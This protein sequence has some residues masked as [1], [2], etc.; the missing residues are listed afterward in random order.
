MKKAI[1]YLSIYE[2]DE[3]FVFATFQHFNYYVN[4]DCSSGVIT[5]A[6]IIEKNDDQLLKTEICLS[7]FDFRYEKFYLAISQLLNPKETELYLLKINDELIDRIKAI[8]SNDIN[9]S[10]I[11]PQGHV[12]L[13]SD[14]VSYDSSRLL[15]EYVVDRFENIVIEIYTSEKCG[16]EEPHVHVSINNVLCC[17]ISLVD[18]YQVL[19]YYSSIRSKTLKKAKMMITNKLSYMRLKWN[20]FS[21]LVK[22]KLDKNGTPT[23]ETYKIKQN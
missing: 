6:T 14:T 11:D 17:K 19:K 23:S 9:V 16:Y 15:T 12:L 10:L 3:S 20:E 13:A 2:A 4:F 8:M 5:K 1:G 21:N 18:G 7:V 22:F